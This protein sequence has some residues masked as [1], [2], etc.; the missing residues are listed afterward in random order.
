MQLKASVFVAFLNFL[1][2][3]HIEMFKNY[4]NIL[5]MITAYYSNNI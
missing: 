4:K 5:T 1:E 2:A 3:Y